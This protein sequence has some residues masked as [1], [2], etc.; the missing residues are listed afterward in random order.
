MRTIRCASAVVL[1]TCLGG[2]PAS[3]DDLGGDVSLDGFRPALDARGFVT[4]DGP[5][6][7]ERGAPSFGLVTSWSRGLLD[8]VDDVVSPTFVAAVGLAWRTELAAALPFGVVSAG[9]RGAQGLGDATL[10]VKTRVYARGPWAFGAAATLTLPTATPGSWLGAGAL[11]G[12]GK[13][14]AE[15]REG[16][17]RAG[18]NAGVHVRSGGDLTAMDV[19]AGATTIPLGA[20]LAWSLGQKLDVIGEVGAAVP[21]AGDLAPSE[22]TGALRVRLAESSHLTLGAGTGLGG[23]AGNPEVRG[24][25]AILF[26]PGARRHERAIFLE[27]PAPPEAPRPG[28]RDDDGLID[29]L[30]ACPDDPEDVDQFEDGDGCPDLDNDRDGITDAADLCP[31]DPEDVDGLEDADGC[32]ETDADGDKLV[33]EDDHC[34]LER[35]IAA[36]QGCPDR[37]RVSLD[38]GELVVFEEIR[39]EFNSAVID[40]A[41]YDIL[42]V[43]AQ[44]IELNTDLALIEIGGHTDARGSDSYNLWLSQ[45]RADAVR[46]FLVGEGVDADRLEAQGY[47]ETMPKIRKRSERAYQANRRVEFLILRRG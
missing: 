4:V 12:G 36:D 42:R 25:L 1:A 29:R 9:D 34:P 19:T 47:G 30:D 35:G 43:I 21:L 41:S 8:D 3:A 22:L 15:W 28:D 23:G 27:P 33:D 13:L 45:Q 5:S 11:A 39:F 6:V 32:P 37:S 14:I 2:A 38:G 46:T 10:S 31:D 24:F 26:E 44:T 40:E 16:R 17:L 18:V 20:A 7:L